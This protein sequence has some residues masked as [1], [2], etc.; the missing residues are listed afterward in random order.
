MDIWSSLV[1]VYVCARVHACALAQMF[2]CACTSVFAY[3][4]VY[5]CARV[6]L[7][8]HVLVSAVCESL[9]IGMGK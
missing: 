3:V 5:Q 6:R 4:C 2:A 8:P 7:R 9:P 1:G